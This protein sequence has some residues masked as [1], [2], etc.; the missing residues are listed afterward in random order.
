M[1]KGEAM[2]LPIVLVQG[3][4]FVSLAIER[5]VLAGIA[6]V[7]DGN[8][9]STEQFN[10][11]LRTASAVLLGTR[12]RVDAQQIAKMP[13]C[14]VIVRYGVGLDNVAVD[15]ATRRAIFVAN[16]PD[17]SITEVSD[18]AVALILAAGR[19]ILVADR[20]ARSSGWGVQVMKGTARLSMQTVGVVGFG[21]IGQAVA[22]KLQ[23]FF[24]RTVAFDPVVPDEVMIEKGVEPVDLPTLL[25]VSDY[26]SLHCPLIPETRYL[27]NAQAI[28]KMKP[29]AWLVNT[30]R[31]ELVDEAALIEA[32]STH[33][34]GG[35]ALDVFSEEPL[36]ADSPLYRLDNV[37]MT[38][39]VAYYSESALADLQR[40][41][42]EQA[43]SVLLGKR[44]KWLC[45][46]AVLDTRI[47]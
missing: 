44:P 34:L 6:T 41:A 26:V 46:P 1:P 38:P 37:I 7:V 29:T 16:V 27:V 43:R 13:E 3:H 14:R 45:N 5:E 40:I 8:A 18:H 2:T 21:R 28:E 12:G 22:R 30:S 15:E 33:R 39:H 31:G 10:E 11:A 47:S 32:L 36:P 17:Y 19:R 42:A 4:R 20:A 25:R 35:A 9:L 24:Q 23:P